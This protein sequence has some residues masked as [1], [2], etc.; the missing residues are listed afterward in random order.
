ML[1]WLAVPGQEWTARST[2]VRGR[3]SLFPYP[4]PVSGAVLQSSEGPGL[5]GRSAQK[6]MLQPS[7]ESVHTMDCR[8]S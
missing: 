8:V 3:L 2:T 5:A 1:L 7:R 6:W 4:L